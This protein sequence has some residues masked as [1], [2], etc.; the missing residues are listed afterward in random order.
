MDIKS[1]EF[2]KA[3]EN[4]EKEIYEFLNLKKAE[5]RQKTGFSVLGIECTFHASQST[6]IDDV[7]PIFHHFLGS[8]KVKTTDDFDDGAVRV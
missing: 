5:F 2:K 1:E 3:K 8:V 7:E 6:Y 4:L